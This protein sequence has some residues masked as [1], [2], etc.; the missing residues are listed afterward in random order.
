M[1]GRR[2]RGVG[3]GA[4]QT[5]PPAPGVDEETAHD[6]PEGEPRIDGGR[7]QTKGMPASAVRIDRGQNGDTRAEDH[8]PADSLDG[9]P[10][11]EDGPGRSGRRENGPGGVDG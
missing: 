5:P 8:G 9:A 6:G 11:D 4:Q 1:R 2:A 3:D 7:I 10:E